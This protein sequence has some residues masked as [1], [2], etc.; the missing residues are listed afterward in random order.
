[1]MDI[2][3]ECQSVNECRLVLNLFRYEEFKK[4]FHDLYMR[5]ESGSDGEFIIQFDDDNCINTVIYDK[6]GYEFLKEF[7][8][9]ITHFNDLD[10]SNEQI[11]VLNIMKNDLNQINIICDDYAKIF[12]IDIFN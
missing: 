4:L 9:E 2:D 6:R 1:M 12:N 3:N 5:F 10:L 11:S 7:C 8:N